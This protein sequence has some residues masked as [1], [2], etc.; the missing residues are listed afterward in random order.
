MKLLFKKY[1]YFLKWSLGSFNVAAFA[2]I[3][4]IKKDGSDSCCMLGAL[5]S[6]TLPFIFAIAL[7]ITFWYLIYKFVFKKGKAVYDEQRERDINKEKL[8][9]EIDE[10]LKKRN[11]GQ[12]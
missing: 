5:G 4:F 7:F 6:L 10:E 3:L 9:R 2:L 11:E 8:L 12:Q 1:E